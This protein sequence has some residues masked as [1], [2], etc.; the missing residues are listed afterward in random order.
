MRTRVLFLATITL[1]CGSGNAVVTAPPLPS[2]TAPISPPPSVTTSTNASATIAP[3]IV[4]PPPPPESP[5]KR[6]LAN[7]PAAP[8]VPARTC[9]T[10]PKRANNIAIPGKGSQ[11]I[12]TIRDYLSLAPIANVPVKVF[13]GDIC[14][15]EKGCRPSHPHP[16]EQLQLVGKTDADGRAIF[17]V[18]DLEY[19][20]VI[21][22]DPIPGY[23]PFSDDYNM[24]KRECHKLDHEW[25]SING[26]GLL[27]DGYLVPT[28][29]LAVKNQD[30]AVAA[31][32]QLPELVAWL[33]DHQDAELILRQSGNFWD[34][35]F[36]YKNNN[37]WL[38]IVNVFDGSA[39]MLGR[40]D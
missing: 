12:V 29:M 19:S 8:T 20:V 25:K 7:P 28:T 21:P 10:V 40:W 9:P 17:D 11:V 2:S 36:G 18:P 4:A 16:P 23:L 32:M 33:R 30:D 3:Q 37:K 24:A 22:E 34:V 27:Y 31:A 6:F 38:V 13:H 15:G 1:G 5:I 35:G 14:L 26:R 39:T